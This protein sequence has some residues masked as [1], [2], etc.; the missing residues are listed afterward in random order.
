MDASNYPDWHITTIATSRLRIAR[1]NLV[2]AHPHENDLRPAAQDLKQCKN[3][4]S[5]FAQDHAK[6]AAMDTFMRHMSKV[7]I[8]ADTHLEF[9]GGLRH[10]DGEHAKKTAEEWE[11]VGVVQL[12]SAMK[13]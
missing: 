3:N 7:C 1:K 8:D 9:Y 11:R 4:A 12:G 6:W 5:Q 10:F 2:A 13:T